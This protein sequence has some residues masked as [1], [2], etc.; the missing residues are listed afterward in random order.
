MHCNPKRATGTSDQI[1]RCRK[2]FS[3]GVLA[4]VDDDSN[5]CLYFIL[6]SSACIIIR[7]SRLK[8][9]EPFFSASALALAFW[10]LF[11]ILFI[12]AWRR[13]L[14][15]SSGLPLTK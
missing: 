2:R 3:S 5:I 7:G 4:I 12:A 9:I 6:A 10:A 15:K 14:V 8:V 13:I 1:R 11:F